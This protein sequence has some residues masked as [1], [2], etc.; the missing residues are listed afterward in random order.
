MSMRY[1]RDVQ[2][3]PLAERKLNQSL[4]V[5]FYLTL[6]H[7]ILVLYSAFFMSTEAWGFISGILFYLLILGYFGFEILRERIKR[8][9]MN[10][11]EILPVVDLDGNLRGTAPRKDC[12]FNPKEKFLHPVVHMHVFDYSGKILLQHRPKTKEVQ[13]DKWDTAVGG[14]ISYGETIEEALTREAREELGLTGFKA[15]FVEKYLWETEVEKELVFTFI[16][17]TS[18]DIIIN[19]EEVT[20]AKFWKLTDVRKMLGKNQ[21]T[22]NFENEFARLEKRGMVK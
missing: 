14:H 13:P 22:P 6:T 5:L 19:K 8:K 4:K 17:Q 12:H 9:K 1:I 20:E 21:F 18:Q 10:Y 2:I 11:D 3:S 15:Q 7:I 16:C